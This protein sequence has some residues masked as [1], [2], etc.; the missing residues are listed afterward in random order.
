MLHYCIPQVPPGTL[1]IGEHCFLIPVR[2]FVKGH[3]L[4]FS[5]A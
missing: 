4:C 2:L 1:E 5:V 3:Y